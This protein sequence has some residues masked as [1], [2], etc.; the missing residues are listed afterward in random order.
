MKQGMQ[1]GTKQGMD[2]GVKQG[3]VMIVGML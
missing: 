2:Q 1:Q 3:M